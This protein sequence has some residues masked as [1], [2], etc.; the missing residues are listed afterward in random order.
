[1]TSLIRYSDDNQSVV[2]CVERDDQW[3]QESFK[4]SCLKPR[5]FPDVYTALAHPIRTQTPPESESVDAEY[6]HVSTPFKLPKGS[7]GL[8]EQ[9]IC[10][11]I[12][13]PHYRYPGVPAQHS[14]IFVYSIQIAGGTA[15]RM[16][17]YQVAQHYTSEEGPYED[18]RLILPL[19]HPRI[20]PYDAQL[21]FPLMGVSFNHIAYIETVIYPWNNK[22]GTYALR[23]ATFPKVKKGHGRIDV[24]VLKDVPQKVLQDAH[25]IFLRPDIAAISI[26]TTDNMLHTFYY[27]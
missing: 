18:A 27:G 6:T 24:K 8:A 26:T 19:I 10:W 1:M 4:V 20:M 12:P 15:G 17:Q 13:P 23:L 16:V 14:H 3:I 21:K 25:Q 7:L 5:A 2:V 11:S 22:A 9:F